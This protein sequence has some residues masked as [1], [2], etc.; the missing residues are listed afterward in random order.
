MKSSKRG[1]YKGIP[2]FTRESE[3]ELWWEAERGIYGWWWRYLRLSPVFWFAR[4]TGIAPKHPVL[5]RVYDA[6]GD[7]G[8]GEFSH[9][10]RD[11]GARLF[12]EETR[13]R[14]TR[15]VD[16]E[17]F[18]EFVFYPPGKSIVIEIPLT[19]SQAT[20]NKQIREIL[21][22]KHPGRGLKV[23]SHSTAQWALHTK[24]FNLKT[25][26]REYWALLYRML[27]PDIAAWRV[28]DRL[29]LAPGLNLRDLDRWK[30]NRTTSPQTRMSSTI[31]RYLYKA[32]WTLWNAEQDS[33]PNANKVTPVEQPFG[34]RHHS[35]Y[36]EAT[37][38]RID[39]VSPWD[40]WLHLEHHEDLV[41]L[42]RRKNNLMGM[43]A[44]DAKMQER[45]PKFIAGES[46]LLA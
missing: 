42:I 1:F 17:N 2:G 43:S 40:E 7:L 39:A 37:G 30:R 15:L 12:V 38:R 45:L 31:G 20:I 23:M 22:D 3:E 27:Y 28:G 25:L 35:E 44:I 32:Q 46:D 19:I 24:R 41:T 9:W 11:T 13:P 4:T 34:K 16:E 21:A 29:K 5:A 36:L 18:G 6:A 14:K 10:W 26:E 8:Q 33:F